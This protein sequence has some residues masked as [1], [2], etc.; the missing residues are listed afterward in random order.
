MKPVIIAPL[1]A[2]ALAASGAG[3]YFWLTSGGGVEEAVITPSPTGV[4]SSPTTGPTPTPAL[5]TYRN[6][7]YG[8]E[9]NYPEGWR[10]TSAYMETFAELTSN[11]R[12]TAVP[13]DYVVLT[14]LSEPEEQQFMEQASQEIGPALSPWYKFAPGQAVVIL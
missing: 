14:T 9:V 5:Q 10:V 12:F 8:Y 3:A 11:P 4:A 6:E 2:L 13:E 1:V 7:K